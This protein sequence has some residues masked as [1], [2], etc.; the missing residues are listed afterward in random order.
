MFFG[1]TLITNACY[2]VLIL[3]S[4]KINNTLIL[5]KKKNHNKAKMKFNKKLITF[6]NYVKTFL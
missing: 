5:C 1:L 4:I 6:K 3:N 2:W